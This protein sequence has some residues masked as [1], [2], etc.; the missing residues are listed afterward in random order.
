MQLSS[1][2]LVQQLV[3]ICIYYEVNLHSLFSNG[4]EASFVSMLSAF[5]PIMLFKI[6]LIGRK[7]QYRQIISTSKNCFVVIITGITCLSV[8]FVPV[9]VSFF[10]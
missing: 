6:W 2:G 8:R 10:S 9:L 5:K 7:F 4:N 3:K 1:I